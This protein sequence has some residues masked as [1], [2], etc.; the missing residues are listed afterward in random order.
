MKFRPCID[1]HNGKVK[2]IVGGSLKD[3]G[4]QAAENFVSE[5]DAACLLYTSLSPFSNSLGIEKVFDTNVLG[6]GVTA[7]GTAA[8]S[9]G[10]SKLEV[11]KVT[12]TTLG[13]RGID[14]DTAGFHSCFEFIH[15]LCFI[16]VDV[17]GRGMTIAAVCNELRSLCNS[18]VKMCI[19][20]SSWP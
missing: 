8:K 18:I 7:P 3:Q 2:Q 1:I 15:L 12:D 4:D 14:K 13:R 10:W 5:Q 17:E 16:Y 20:D 6:Y 11:V 9:K 19:R